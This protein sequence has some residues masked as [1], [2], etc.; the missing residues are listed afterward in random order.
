MAI[1]IVE[2]YRFNNDQTIRTDAVEFMVE[3]RNAGFADND[4]KWIVSQLP[5]LYWSHGELRQL[6]G[7]LFLGVFDTRADAVIVIESAKLQPVDDRVVR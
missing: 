3:Q 2:N 4:G 1:E 5:E 7:S 6:R